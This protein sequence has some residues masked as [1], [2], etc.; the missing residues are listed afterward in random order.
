MSCAEDG[1][2]GPSSFAAFA[3]VTACLHVPLWPSYTSPSGRAREVRHGVAQAV[4]GSEQQSPPPVPVSV[5]MPASRVCRQIATPLF[6]G[7]CRKS[8]Q[9]TLMIRPNC[10]HC[11]IRLCHRCAPPR[12]LLGTTQHCQ[13]SRAWGRGG[14]GVPDKTPLTLLPTSDWGKLFSR[15]FGTGQCARSASAKTQDHQA[16]GDPPLSL[17]C[18]PQKKNWNSGVAALKDRALSI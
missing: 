4:I 12:V 7:M 3:C 2:L 11:V 18:P 16:G 8:F 10:C 14:D 17:T 15:R 1:P 5:P 13:G 6:S 9:R